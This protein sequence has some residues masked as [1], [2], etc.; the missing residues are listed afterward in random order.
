MEIRKCKR[1]EIQRVGAFY[2]EVVAYLDEHVN[3]PRWM[4]KVYPTVSSVQKSTKEDCQFV[5]VDNGQIVGAFVLCE[6]AEGEYLQVD[7]WSLPLNI[8]Q[9]IVCHALATAPHLHRKGLGKQIVAYCINYAK[10]H[11]YRA[12]RLDV[13]PDNEPAKRLYESFGFT[14]VCDNELGRGYEHIPTFSLY[15]LNF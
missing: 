6:D 2:D 13:V 12:M 7:S 9:Y 10:Q 15:E 1:S 14:F 3:Y 4:Y 5:C 11:G 8:S